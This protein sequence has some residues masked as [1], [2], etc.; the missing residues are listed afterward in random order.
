MRA[1]VAVLLSVLMIV[2][3]GLAADPGAGPLA[4]TLDDHIGQVRDG[5]DQA[6]ETYGPREEFR[7]ARAELS[8]SGLSLLNNA[9]LL[10]EDGLIKASA[11]MA[12]GQSRAQAQGSADPSGQVVEDAEAKIAQAD[13]IMDQVRGDLSSMEQTGLEP[14][15]LDGGL[16]V[17]HTLIRAMDMRHQYQIGMRSWDEGDHTEEVVRAVM[18]GA[19][20]ALRMAQVAEDTLGNVAEARQEAPPTPVL[21]YESL[22]T[23]T[24]ERFR[25]SQGQGSPVVEHSQ[26]RVGAIHSNGERLMTLAAYMTLF[27]DLAFN[28]LQADHQRDSSTTDPYRIARDLLEDTADPVDAW[29]DELDIP[30]DLPTGA[31]AS[32]RLTLTLSENITGDDRAN[33]GAYAASLVHLGAEHVGILQ[34]AYGGPDHEPGTQLATPGQTEGTS[35]AGGDGLPIWLVAG[36]GAV[37][38]LAVVRFWRN[39]T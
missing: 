13:A 19:A 16:A 26:A 35:E 4:R 3:T 17:A 12:T 31:I 8:R 24:E 23:I 11:A 33:S 1:G 10:A 25:W 20:G 15:A 14:V 5:L 18:T 30:G 28:G 9:T 22:G 6:N 36:L 39:Q 34:Q 7:L 27:Q 29:V 38:L 21:S 37:I 2:P 32:G